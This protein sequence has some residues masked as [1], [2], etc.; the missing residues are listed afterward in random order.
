MNYQ[1]LARKWRPRDFSQMIGQHHVLRAL[2]NALDSSRLHHAYLFTG[3]RGVGKT[4]IARILAKCLNCEQGVSST[5]CQQCNTCQ[6]ID[7]GRF[8]DLIE[9]DAAS[10]TKVEDTRELLDN[11]QYTAT[12]G[13]YKIYLIDEVHMLSNHS[14]NALLKT[15]EEPPPHVKFILATTDPQKLPVT[16]LSRCLQFNLKHL[17]KELI[18]QQFKHILVAENINHEAAALALLSQ[19]ANGS[20]RDG[21]SLLDQAIAFGNNE[22]KETQVRELL[23]NVAQDQIIH[24]LQALVQQDATQLF[25]NINSIAEFTSDFSQVLEEV[26]SVLHHIALLQFVPDTI[27]PELND[28]E[29]IKQ[30]ANNLSK[31]DVQLFYQIGL[32]GRRD[33]PFAPTSKDGFEM[34]MLR[35]LAFRPANQTATSLDQSKTAANKP[36]SVN[37]TNA[38]NAVNKMVAADIKNSSLKSDKMAISESIINTN[39]VTSTISS[40]EK[41]NNSD[42]TWS[43][44]IPQLN[45]TE[46]TRVLANHCVLIKQD[47]KEIQ[48]SIAKAYAALASDMQRQRLTQALQEFVGNAVKVNIRID[49][50]TEPTPAEITKQAKQEK[51]LATEQQLHNNQFVQKLMSSFDAKIKPGS[52]ELITEKV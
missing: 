49:E 9:V 23:G 51:L 4:T 5:P 36:V 48:L 17:S 16:I 20:M 44:M 43:Q 42:L 7:A 11:V 2:I 28:I 10:R 31:E 25:T 29:L 33:L 22:I 39:P 21:L 27:I 32:H 47:N 12:Q 34:T 8:V 19:A 26:L 41:A 38:S 45:L 30:L 52:I 3:T 1:V 14:F 35:M 18:M 40:S 24:L 15:L 37:N 50:V 13:R 46:P 6:A